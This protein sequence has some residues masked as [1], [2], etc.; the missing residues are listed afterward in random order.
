M[1]AFID[2]VKR[3]KIPVALMVICLFAPIMPLIGWTITFFWDRPEIRLE[4]PKVESIA[5]PRLNESLSL[6]S[7]SIGKA[8]IT[9]QIEARGL[10][11]QAGET[12]VVNWVDVWDFI[13]C[14]PS[15]VDMDATGIRSAPRMYEVEI[16]MQAWRI[17]SVD[18]DCNYK[19]ERVR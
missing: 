10:P 1:S 19:L 17:V 8:A 13:P 14:S 15:I 16:G 18:K 6:P 5:F 12:W 7:T 11:P 4:A 3:E 9:W 2:K